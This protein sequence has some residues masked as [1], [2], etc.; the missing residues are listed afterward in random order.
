MLLN[1]LAAPKEYK[2]HMKIRKKNT[3]A[4]LFLPLFVPSIDDFHI[5]ASFKLV[6]HTKV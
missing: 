6:V 5:S 2:I 3:S 4:S 1:G